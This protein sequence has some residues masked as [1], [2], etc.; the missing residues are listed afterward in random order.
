MRKRFGYTFKQINKLCH[1][2]GLKLSQ[3]TIR[4]YYAHFVPQM[5]TECEAALVEIEQFT[6]KITILAA[7]RTLDSLESRAQMTGGYIPLDQI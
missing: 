2:N 7:Q 1:E 3:S 4:V 6:Q 5:K